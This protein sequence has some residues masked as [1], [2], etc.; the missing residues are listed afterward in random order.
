ME[1]EMAK[2]KKVIGASKIKLPELKRKVYQLA[3]VDNTKELKSLNSEFASLDFRLKDTWKYVL[4]KFEAEESFEEWRS[5]PPEKYKEVFKE[6]EEASKDHQFHVASAK[7]VFKGL[8]ES[9]EELNQLTKE[10]QKDVKALQE[11]TLVSI[12]ISL[13][14]DDKT[15]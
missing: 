6:I 2:P 12:P 7:K 5:N 13:P 11:E 10:V 8:E 14:D 9:V 1:H 15:N 3:G 4:T